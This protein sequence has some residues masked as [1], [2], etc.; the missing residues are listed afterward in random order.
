LPVQDDKGRPLPDAQIV[1][2]KL[3]VVQ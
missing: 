3:D 2:A 1:L